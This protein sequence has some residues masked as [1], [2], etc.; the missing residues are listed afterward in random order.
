MEQN[1]TNARWNLYRNGKV[2]MPSDPTYET[3]CDQGEASRIVDG[4]E[5]VGYEV[6]S[7]TKL[8]KPWG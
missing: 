4:K 2:T 8:P 6:R 5:V 3:L 1:I 7:I